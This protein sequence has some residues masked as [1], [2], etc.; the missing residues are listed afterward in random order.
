MN[1]I[2]EFR[3][4]AV[5]CNQKTDTREAGSFI[6]VKMAVP[7]SDEL[8]HQFVEMHGKQMI[9]GIDAVGAARETGTLSLDASFEFAGVDIVTQTEQRSGGEFMSFKLTTGFEHALFYAL[10]AINGS[11]TNVVIEPKQRDMFGGEE[12]PP[13]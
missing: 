6:T 3:S 2:A 10:E 12:K 11:E 5:K 8:F 13:E 7:H 9:V 4:M 1:L